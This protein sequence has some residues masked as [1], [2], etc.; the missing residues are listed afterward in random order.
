MMSK[1]STT[2]SERA[3]KIQDSITMAVSALAGQLK[4]EGHNVLSFSAGEPD[5]DTPENIKQA[6][7]QSL[8]EGKTKYTAVSGIPELKDAIVQKF[9]NENNIDYKASNILVSCGAK[10]SIINAILAVINPGDEVIVPSPYWVSYPEQIGLAEGVTVFI[11]TTDKENFKLRPAQ[12][13]AAITPKTKMLILNSPSNPTGSVYT[14][15]ELEEIVNIAVDNDIWILSDEIYEKL[16]YEGTEHVSVASLSERIKEKSIIVNG[17][18][19]AYSMTGWRI[20]YLAAPEAVTK[21]AGKIQSHTTSNPNTTA[22]WASVEA[23]AGNQDAVETMRVEF[24]K[25]RKI[26]IAGLK[27]IDGITCTTP[28]GA[29]YAFPNVSALYGKSSTVGVI[30]SSV[31]FCSHLLEEHKMA[32]VPGSGFG[33]DDYI[34]LSYATDEATINQGLEKLKTFVESLK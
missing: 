20:G 15:A 5:F 10:Q 4:K 26:M 17:V 9:K 14:R 13:K 19:K 11:E 18:A 24:D 27:K 8:K 29:F 31:E 33:A 7:V 16:L 25:R 1:T 28:Q 2:L 23:I 6:A 30:N 34:R 12:L 22:Q 32:C 21:A 3:N